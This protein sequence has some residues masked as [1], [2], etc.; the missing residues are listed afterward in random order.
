MNAV[1]G[2][3]P[4]SVLHLVGFRGLLRVQYSL[5]AGHRY[6]LQAQVLGY[7]ALKE[8]Q[9]AGTVGQGVKHF[10]GNAPVAIF[11][12][13]K[14]AAVLSPAQRRA[15]MSHI[16]G[17]MK[18]VA[19]FLQVIP[20]QSL[21]KADAKGRKAGQHLIYCVL[22]ALGRYGLGHH[23]GEAEHA[24]PLNAGDGG[25]QLCGIIQAE[26]L[27]YTALCFQKAVTSPVWVIIAYSPQNCTENSP[28]AC[29]RLDPP[30][31]FV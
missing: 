19:D 6:T 16:L 17:N 24:R 30:C 21:A 5:L 4:V 2:N 11:H 28:D 27:A 10:Q 25:V 8:Y 13:K 26:P 7:D 29:A 18:A 20:E 9:P 1:Q 31:R 3:F 22:Q 14:V 23:K 12:P 15:R